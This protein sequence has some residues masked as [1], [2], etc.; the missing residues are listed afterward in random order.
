MKKL[1]VFVAFGALCFLMS[2]CVY[3]LFP[4]YTQDT[5][6]YLPE[7]VGKWQ[8]NSENPEEYILFE[9]TSQ[10]KRK[11]IG[12]EKTSRPDTEY[13]FGEQAKI[14][15][16]QS[17]GDGTTNYKHTMSGDGWKIKSD[18]PITVDIDGETISDPVMVKSYYDSLFGSMQSDMQKGLGK[19]VKE[20]DSAANS[21]GSKL[22]KALNDLGNGLG[23]LG[24][25]LK[26]AE[27]KFKGT[28]Y[29]STEESYRMT[30]SD[31]GTIQSYMV[32]IV[33]IGSEYF[34]DMYPLPE[35]TDN[36]FSENL[37]P[38]HTFMKLDVEGDRL[39][40][41]PFDLEKLNELFESN[42]IRLRHEYVDGNVVITAQPK[43]IQKFLSK[44][45]NDETVFE[46]V[47]SYNRLVQ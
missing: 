40:L 22:N 14:E 17:S 15:M 9:P 1:K 11:E 45:S 30:V 10:A 38:V 12:L 36:T 26:K 33:E 16:T 2:S 29:V 3:S 24:D 5:L 34:M 21:E 44:Y 19:M 20:L 7:L 43:E 42:L 37:F 25:A 31:D 46:E 13:I 27:A 39:S 8:T 18:G 23:K 4:I 32:H 28:A 6:V 41:I 47:E 35:F